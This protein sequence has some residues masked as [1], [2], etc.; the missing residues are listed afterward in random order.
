[1]EVTGASGENHRLAASHRQTLWILRERH[2]QVFATIE[3][4]GCRDIDRVGGGG[5]GEMI[6]TF[7]IEN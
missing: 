6:K 4:Y 3:L 5:R 2:M 7:F 1:M